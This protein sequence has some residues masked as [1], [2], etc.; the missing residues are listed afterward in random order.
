MVVA[1]VLTTVARNVFVAA[2]RPIGW[3]VASA[4]VAVL[5]AP[6]A[7]WT[8]R[9]LERGV[10]VLLTVL[11]LAGFVLAVAVGV[12][13]DLRLEVDRLKEALPAAAGRLE[14][15][16]GL[17]DVAQDFRLQERVRSF[18]DDLDERVS[19]RSSLEEAA[20]TAPAYFVNGILVV[21]FLVWGPRT[22]AGFLRQFSDE[23][24]RRRCEH[25]IS[26]AVRRARGYVLAVLAQAVVI[27]VASAGLLWALGV[28]TPAVLGVVVGS[29]SLVPYVGVLFGCVPAL[30]L[31][32][33]FRP[34]AVT[35]VLVAF[36]VAV[37]A[38]SVAVVHQRV[39]RRTLRVGPAVVVAAAVLGF[40]V[41]GLGGALYGTVLV[42]FAVAALEVATADDGVPAVAGGAP[43][44]ADSPPAG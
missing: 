2:H 10:A 17:G 44:R 15:D 19:R 20:G 16:E 3:A 6:V 33:G 8:S 1:F 27:G 38:A 7:R 18:V 39:H 29:M 23:D 13:A 28:P 25:V 30:L 35:A 11:A 36:F 9:Y 22:Y 42:V 5:L 34:G 26:S 32:A 12:F 41:Y 4:T 40:E 14:D 21:F 31:A 37:Q 24:Q 43:E